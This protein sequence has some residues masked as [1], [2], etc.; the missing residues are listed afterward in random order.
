MQDEGFRTS[1]KEQARQRVQEVQGQGESEPRGS[2]LKGGTRVAGSA[3]ALNTGFCSKDAPCLL[4]K[5]CLWREQW[6]QAYPLWL[7]R[8]GDTS[9]P[10]LAVSCSGE[11]V[12]LAEGNEGGVTGHKG[13]P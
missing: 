13:G 9:C 6:A 12:A 5:P 2:A 10:G 1:E 7:F 11:Y 8:T 3:G 4:G